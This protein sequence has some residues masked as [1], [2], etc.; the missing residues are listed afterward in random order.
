[1]LVLLCLAFFGMRESNAWQPHG[2][3]ADGGTAVHPGMNTGL[4]GDNAAASMA[5]SGHQGHIHGG[6]TTLGLRVVASCP[7]VSVK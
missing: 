5:A 2:T 7:E 4:S 1:M 3:P 6:G